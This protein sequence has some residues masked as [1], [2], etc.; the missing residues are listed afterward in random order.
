MPIKQDV[1]MSIFHGGE[2]YGVFDALNLLKQKDMNEPEVK[3]ALAY[4]INDHQL[5][6]TPD[7]RLRL[8]TLQHA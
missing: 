5:E 1:V 4:L 7:R 6:F 3:E 2:E 8:G